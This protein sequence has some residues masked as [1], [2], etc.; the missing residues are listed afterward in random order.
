MT[1]ITAGSTLDRSVILGRD[2]LLLL[3][4]V[5]CGYSWETGGRISMEKERERGEKKEAEALSCGKEEY[6]Q[7]KRK[8]I[9]SIYS[10]NW[11]PTQSLAL[12]P[13]RGCMK[14]GRGKTVPSLDVN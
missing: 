12:Q 1:L 5:R 4:Q 7:C 10:R 11:G 6:S 3:I 2:V 9:P 14:Q 8:N 13:K